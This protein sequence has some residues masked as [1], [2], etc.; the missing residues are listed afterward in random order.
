MYFIGDLN[1]I[2]VRLAVDIDQHRGLPIRGD[3][4]VKRADSRLYGCNVAYPH[5]DAGLGCLDDY[6]G[7]LGRVSYLTADQPQK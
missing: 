3:N 4:G 7:N 6:V 2:A 1:G 5:W